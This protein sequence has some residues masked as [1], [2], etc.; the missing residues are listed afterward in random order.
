M[1]PPAG[2]VIA[3]L[4]LAPA[5]HAGR[6]AE[7]PKAAVP[8]AAAPAAAT[9]SPSPPPGAPEYQ[10][11]PGDVIEVAVFGNEDLSRLPTI[12]PNG[13]IALPLLGEVPV[14]GLTVAEIRAK[15]T[16]L[17]AKD[18]L[19]NP[20]VEVKIKEYQSQFVSVVG[21]VNNPG[22]KP[23]KGRTRLIDVLVEAGGFRP[24]ASGEVIIN[25]ADGS[26]D[27][28]AKTLRLKLGSAPTPQDQ[29]NLELPLRNGD[30]ITASPKYFVT[31]EGEVNRPGRYPIENDLTVMG[32]VSTAGGLTRFGSTDVRVRRVDPQSGQARIIEVDLKSVR[33]GRQEDPLLLPNDVV[34]VSRRVF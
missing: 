14:S 12:Q 30:L 29:V 23:L 6:E 4:L 9:P 8:Q 10:V 5:A 20:Q 17:L 28:G 2:L 16:A 15:L 7:V 11:G 27:G 34:S 32:A 25:R 13:T 24:S 3:T 21:E 18:F 31:V 19:V 26:F 22:R 1:K 33:K